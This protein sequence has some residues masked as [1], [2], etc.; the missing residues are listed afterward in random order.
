MIEYRKKNKIRDVYHDFRV[1]PVNFNTENKRN[2]L[3][4]IKQLTD[5]EM[6]VLDSNRH[7]NL[8]TALRTAQANDMILDKKATSNLMTSL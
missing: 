2:M 3:L 7:G 4:N 1:I 5:M 6:V 8:I